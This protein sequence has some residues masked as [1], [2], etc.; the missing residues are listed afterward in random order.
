ML[1]HSTAVSL[2]RMARKPMAPHGQAESKNDSKSGSHGHA[3]ALTS[4]YAG[5]HADHPIRDDIR[6]VAVHQGVQDVLQTLE[7]SGAGFRGY[8]WKC[9]VLR[10]LSFDPCGSLRPH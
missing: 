7:L 10:C 3:S 6:A 8:E 4:D 9:R 1:R 5:L 2:W